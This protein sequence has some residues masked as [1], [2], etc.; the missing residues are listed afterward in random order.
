[1]FLSEPIISKS[2]RLSLVPPP[3]SDD[4]VVAI[5]RAH[6]ATRQYLRDLPTQVALDDA[7]ARR[8][9]RKADGTL[10]EFHI[11]NATNEFLGSTAISRID[12]AGEWCDVSIMVVSE[13]TRT[14]VATDALYTLLDYVFGTKEMNRAE[15][16]TAADNVPMR[17]WLER[18]GAK[19]QGVGQEGE[20]DSEGGGGGT[21]YLRL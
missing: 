17:G 10:I 19:L 8:L 9:E 4:A 21:G 18:T 11:H 2:G 20:A 5:L 13:H 1:M 7:A 16:Q 15:F 12:P 6:P 14:G 3:E